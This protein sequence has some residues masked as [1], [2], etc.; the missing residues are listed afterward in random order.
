MYFSSLYLLLIAPNKAHELFIANII[1]SLLIPI[2]HIS[3]ETET[4]ICRYCFIQCEWNTEALLS[5]GK[6]CPGVSRTD[7]TH[8][9]VCVFCEYHSYYSGHVRGHLRSHIGDKPFKC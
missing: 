7:K 9:Y 2:F 6:R 8:N 5:H 1:K 3:S 4:C